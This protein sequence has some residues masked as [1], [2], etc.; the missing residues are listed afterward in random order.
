MRLDGKFPRVSQ[1][2]SPSSSS[3]F[4]IPFELV[5]FHPPP[6][7]AGSIAI[8][9]T[10]KKV[11]EESARALTRSLAQFAH[12]APLGHCDQIRR[13]FSLKQGPKAPK[14]GRGAAAPSWLFLDFL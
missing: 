6:S 14:K 3:C 2:S 11:S 12:S 10:R 5:A 9:F 1:V 8:L 13:L 7:P 4:E